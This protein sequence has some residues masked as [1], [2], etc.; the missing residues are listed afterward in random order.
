MDGQMDFLF[1]SSSSFF[2][3]QK[4]DH[5]WQAINL[6]NFCI[7]EKKWRLRSLGYP[8]MGVSSHPSLSV[9]LN[10]K[11]IK[12]LKTG[13]IEHFGVVRLE[14]CNLKS[15]PTALTEI[16]PAVTRF[17]REG[18]FT[19]FTSQHLIKE[20]LGF[21]LLDVFCL[22]SFQLHSSHHI[23]HYLC[24]RGKP[25]VIKCSQALKIDS[26][27]EIWIYQGDQLEAHHV[28]HL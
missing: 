19:L 24:W 7:S 27:T 16:H 2:W 25:P 20:S 3:D 21:S 10:K 15:S 9:R 5:R 23:F 8:Y 1:F 12:T 18:A 4:G 6:N 28:V 17:V 14:F 26:Y 13:W 22:S 11:V